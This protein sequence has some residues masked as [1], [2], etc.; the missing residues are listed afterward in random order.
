MQGPHLG[1]RALPLLVAALAPGP[2]PAQLHPLPPRDAPLLARVER[3]DAIVLARVASHSAGR[4]TLARLR[5]LS[6]ATAESFE[7][8]RSPLR[9]PPYRPGDVA[10]FFLRGARPPYLLADEPREML[11]PADAAEAERLAGAVAALLA[12]RESPERLL[13]LH[14]DWLASPDEPLRRLAVNALLDPD[15]PWAPLPPGFSEA[16]AREAADPRRSPAERRA[17][18]ELALADDAG[19][20]A[21]VARLPGAEG[22][23]DPELALLALQAA[24]RRSPPGAQAALA[25]SLRHERPEIRDAAVRAA[26]SLVETFEPELRAALEAL[27]AGEPDAALRRRAQDL[28]RAAVGGRTSLDH[29]ERPAPVATLVLSDLRTGP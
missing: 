24:A 27:A 7:V 22:E 15:A 5:G 3:S 21:L 26:G 25:R 23:A 17:C 8:K 19:L 29:M 4:L 1:R 9:P 12:A 20:A 14:V 11:R 10:V 28:L 13:A 2:A 16:R 18:A 6:G